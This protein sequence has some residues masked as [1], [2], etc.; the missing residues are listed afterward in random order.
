MKVKSLS[1]LCLFVAVAAVYG[2]SARSEAMPHGVVNVAEFV[3]SDGSVDVADGIQ[4]L[5]DANPNRTLWFSDGTYLISHP[6]CTPAHPKRSV[7]LRLSNY[8]VLK[9]KKL[10]KLKKFLLM[11]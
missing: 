9:A 6:I 4:R 7:D 2:Y 8:A 1:A 11:K 3:A 5:I 10:M